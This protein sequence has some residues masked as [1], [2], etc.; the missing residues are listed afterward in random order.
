M[1]IK[2]TLEQLGVPVAN[3]VYEG[4]EETYIVFN[5]YNQAALLSADDVEISTKFFYQVD[6][7]S[8]Y[9]YT[10]LVKQLRELMREAGFGRMFES[11]TY[12]TNMKMYRKIMRFSY[13]TNF[14]EVI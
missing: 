1:N 6:I 14:E 10:D 4:S 2:Q 7:F 9:N 3:S 8:K 5:E 11:E 13:A 12:E